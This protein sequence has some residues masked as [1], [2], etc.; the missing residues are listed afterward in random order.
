MNR[1][2]WFSA[3]TVVLSVFL[4]SMHSPAQKMDQQAIDKVWPGHRVGFDFYT[5]ANYQYAFYY[6]AD[7]NMVIA[8]RKWDSNI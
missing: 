1:K 2:I 3:I 4:I 5:S 8:Q 6:N 7:R